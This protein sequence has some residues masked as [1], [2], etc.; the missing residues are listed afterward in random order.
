M[1]VIREPY[2]ATEG[3]MIPVT[4]G[5]QLFANGAQFLQ[6]GA[7]TSYTN[8]TTETSLYTGVTTYPVN[9]I[10]STVTANY[11]KDYPLS[12]SSLIFPANGLVPGTIIHV[13]LT[14]TIQSTGTPT[15]RIRA[16]LVNPSA[17]FTSLNDSTA[18]ALVA[19]TGTN[20]FVLEYEIIVTAI[21]TSGSLLT[22]GNLTYGSSTTALTTN[23]WSL[24][25]AAATID[26]TLAQ[27]FDIRA[28]WGAASA[29]NILINKGG[30]I[31]Y[32]G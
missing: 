32:I 15:L 30:Y 26:T 19:I 4:S 23:T 24:V 10:A 11:G 9:G 31:R 29:S 14:G 17:T 1:P 2:Q 3:K 12:C 21:G 25:G 8:S 18:V 20:D 28:T 16:G 22:R 13:R 5:T 6:Y 27:T 7:A